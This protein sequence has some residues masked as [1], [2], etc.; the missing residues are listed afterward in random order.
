M[1]V[2]AEVAVAMEVVVME[3]EEGMEGM[4]EVMQAAWRW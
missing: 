4:E 1:G 3:V 2:V